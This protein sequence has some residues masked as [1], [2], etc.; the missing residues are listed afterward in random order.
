[1]AGDG[2]VKLKTVESLASFKLGIKVF[3][4]NNFYLQERLLERGAT[5]QCWQI[6]RKILKAGSFVNSVFVNKERSK[7]LNTMKYNYRMII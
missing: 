4:T 7:N 1:M 5:G 6:H 3:R 2:V